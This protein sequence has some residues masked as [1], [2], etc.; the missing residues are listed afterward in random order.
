MNLLILSY[1]DKD[2]KVFED[3]TLPEVNKLVS[4]KQINL[5]VLLVNN[6]DIKEPLY[7]KVDQGVEL[8]TLYLPVQKNSV[9][10]LEWFLEPENKTQ[11]I[12]NLEEILT[13]KTFDIIQIDSIIFSLFIQNIIALSHNSI[14]IYRQHFDEIDS[15][16]MLSQN[17]RLAVFKSLTINKLANKLKSILEFTLQ[18]FDSIITS[19]PELIKKYKFHNNYFII[20]NKLPEKPEQKPQ[21]VRYTHNLFFIGPLYLIETQHGILWFINEVWPKILREIPN[22]QLHIAGQSEQWFIDILKQKTNVKYYPQVEDIEKFMADKTIMILPYD[23]TI[24]ILPQFL[25]AIYHGKIIIAHSDAVHGWELTAMINFMPVRNS[26]Q[27]VESIIHIYQKN[28]IQQYFSKQILTF[29]DEK[30]TDNYLIEILANFYS[31]LTK[32]HPE[33]GEQ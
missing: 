9:S 14:T 12:N 8:R 13:E 23:K 15:V 20:P 25:Q 7:E 3:F 21:T 5:T 16:L 29:A 11:I 33:N 27:F 6:T 22:L 24:G 32:K 4:R 28:E 17:Y 19:D 2:F 31:K 10:T 1:Q 30:I 18:K 26:Q